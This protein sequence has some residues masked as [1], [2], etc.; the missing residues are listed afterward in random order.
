MNHATTV[1]VA[2]FENKNSAKT[3]VWASTKIQVTAW[4]RIVGIEQARYMVR[5]FKRHN[6]RV[7]VSVVNKG[8]SEEEAK[9]VNLRGDEDVWLQRVN[10]I[11]V[12]AFDSEAARPSSIFRAFK[13]SC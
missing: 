2:K 1:A 11:T 6:T 8:R 4:M 12:S 13:A 10:Q 3:R 7:A 5:G 9:K